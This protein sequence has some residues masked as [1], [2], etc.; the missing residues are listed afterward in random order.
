[1]SKDRTADWA[2]SIMAV[3]D[4]SGKGSDMPNDEFTWTDGSNY[5]LDGFHFDQT[6]GEG[7]R[8]RGDQSGMSGPITPAQ[9][10]GMSDLP[11][12]F[13][14]DN[15]KAEG[16]DDF[17]FVDEEPGLFD[18]GVMLSPNEGGLH[19]TAAERQAASLADLDWLDPTQ[20][21]DPER[22]PKEL[23]PDKP[24]LHSL[25]EL[26]EAWGV[27][28]RTDGL[29]LIPNRDKAT[30]DYEKSIESGLPATPG[31]EKNADAAWHIKKAVRMSHYGRTMGEISNY[32]HANLTEP[33]ARKVHA[34]IAAEH[35]VAGNVFVRASAFPGLR[36]GKWVKDLKKV[37]RTARYV[38]TA[39]PAVAAKLGM[40]MVAEVPYRKALRQYLPLL[41]ASGYKVANVGN[42]PKRTLQY[43]FLLG[44]KQ[45]DHVPSTKPVD[46]RPAD[47]ISL[48]AAMVAAAKEPKRAQSIIS[49]DDTVKAREAVRV[50]IRKAREVGLLDAREAAELL[51]SNAPPGAVRKAAERLAR[52]RLMPKEAEYTGEGTRLSARAREVDS[53]WKDLRQEQLFI[54]QMNKAGAHVVAMVDAGQLTEKE[55]RRALSESTPEMMLKVAAAYANSNSQRKIRLAAAPPAKNYEGHVATQAPQQRVATKKLAADEKAMRE[56][57]ASSGIRVAEFQ[58]MAGWVRRQMSEGMA[59]N[60]LTAMMRIRFASPLRTAA[61]GLIALLR[62]EHEGLSGHLYVDAAAYAS[63]TGTKGCEAAASKHRANQV[64]FVKAME[65]CSGCTLANDN[66]ICTKYGKELLH[67]LPKNAA[68][69]KNRMV[70]AADAPDHEITAG[71]FDPGDFNLGNPMSDLVLDEPALT[72]GIGDVLFG[73]GMS[74]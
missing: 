4:P 30:A 20:E 24:P 64:P 41:T 22:L 28:R 54:S 33:V 46:V 34:R 51:D 47:T 61:E 43:A 37:A 25:P 39:D 7:T 12:G 62:E 45:A 53:A 49:R 36:K 56:A 9:T 74:F 35:G 72:E 57:S 23:R 38:I 68:D 58:A 11:D 1:V 55:G 13:V 66:G 40:Q 6:M 44:P 18:L 29:A 14:S 42:D 59:G 52:A 5:G 15:K 48:E 21:Q 27:N 70:H 3:S 32:L 16:E 63:K 71:L 50:Q 60:D 31:V 8:N 73:D 17:S 19:M 69:F 2:D 65:R 67:K 10:S 26:E